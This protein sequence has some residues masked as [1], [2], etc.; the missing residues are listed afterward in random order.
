ME[1]RSEYSSWE[2]AAPTSEPRYRQYWEEMP[3][4]LSLH[5]RE[6]AI[7]DGNRRFRR[8]FGDCVGENC[9]RVYKGREEVCPSCPVEATFLDGK[10]HGSEQL[11]TT[12]EGVA[13]PVM[14]RTTPIRDASGEVVAVMEMHTDIAEVKRLQE[15]LE[16]SQQQLQQLFA[17][18]PCFIAVQGAGL[19]HSPRQPAIHRDLRRGGRG[20]LLSGLQAPRREVPRV[21]DAAD[22]CRWRDPHARGGPDLQDGRQ[23]Q[24]PV[25]D[26]ADA[27]RQGEVSRPSSRWA[28]TSRRSANCRPS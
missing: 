27:Q 10:S 28:S 6:F 2:D 4:Y 1:A 14:V 15:K 16:E 19:G 25:H 22:L 7:I 9:Y 3:C 23:A 13:V 20:G 24:R 8:D 5:D 17:E 21:P 12:Q 11:L 18:V 26:R